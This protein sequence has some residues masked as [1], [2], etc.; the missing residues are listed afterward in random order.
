MNNYLED[1]EMI[2][3]L[4]KVFDEIGELTA[5]FKEGICPDCGAMDSL[6]DIG[7]LKTMCSNCGSGLISILQEPN[8]DEDSLVS[9]EQKMN[10]NG[11]LC[12]ELVLGEENNVGHSNSKTNHAGFC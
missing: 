2:L 4:E 12:G 3:E 1:N 5:K 11:L 6:V 10:F 9:V 8:I 7:N